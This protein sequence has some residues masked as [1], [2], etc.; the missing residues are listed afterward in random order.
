MWDC[1][2]P[3][4]FTFGAADTFLPP[5]ANFVAFDLGNGLLSIH[6]SRQMLQ[7]WLKPV[8][9]REAGFLKDLPDGAFGKKSALYLDD[10]PDLR[11]AR[12]ALIGLAEKEAASVRR[13]LYP[14]AGAFA[15]GT[16]ADLGNVRKAEPAFLVSLF[17]ELLSGGVLPILVGGADELPIAQFLAYQETKALVNFAVVD[18]RLR[19]ALDGGDGIY[20][21]VLAPRHPMLFHFGIVGLQIHQTPPDMLAFLDSQNFDALRLGRLRPSL[22]E[23]EPVLRDADLLAFHLSAMRQS[24]APGASGVSP[25]GLFS[26]EACQL[27]R[28]AGMSDKLTSFGIYGHREPLDRDDQTAQLVAQMVWYFADGFF[29][30]KQDF[31]ASVAGLTE[32]IVDLPSL[33]H[34]IIFWKSAK[35]GRWWMQVPAPARRK[36]LRHRLVPCSYQDYQ[37]A[38]REDLPE[39][40][41]R[42]MSR[43][44]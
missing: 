2:N 14:M 36:H 33:N 11:R 40:L 26:E 38:V 43:F 6:S 13:F 15:D 28:Y 23:A 22:D 42:A 18:A 12:I 4:L 31:P 9:A 34:Q 24:E 1:P 27:C 41:A 39:R 8:P 35:S 25:S 7:N 20:N 17:G 29:S 10:L 44:G 16:F 37:A 3:K 19:A 5:K 30:R 21:K 32:Y